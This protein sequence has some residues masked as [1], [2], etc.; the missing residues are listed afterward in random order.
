MRIGYE[1]DKVKLYNFMKQNDMSYGELSSKLGK[2]ASYISQ[3]MTGRLN[4][5][6]DM[7]TKLANVMET[8]ED[9]II[10]KANS[11]Y[12]NVNPGRRKRSV[13]NEGAEDIRPTFEERMEE[14]IMTD[15]E[16]RNKFFSS[17]A[18]IDEMKKRI[19]SRCHLENGGEHKDDGVKTKIK[20]LT[21]FISNAIVNGKKNIDTLDIVNILL[22]QS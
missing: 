7:L 13:D 21:D 16:R 14:L 2:S 1:I 12:A 17:Q 18:F 15:E 10:A 6:D 20:E 22:D 8:E 4:V 5:S 9:D 19:C 11:P 3:I